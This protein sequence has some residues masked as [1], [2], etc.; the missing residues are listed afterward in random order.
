MDPVTPT[1]RHI[2]G[3][4]AGLGVLTLAPA[5]LGAAPEKTNGETSG[6]SCELPI[7]LAKLM[8]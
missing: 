8:A 7:R 1:R 5:S 3:T 4:V 6:A 2:L